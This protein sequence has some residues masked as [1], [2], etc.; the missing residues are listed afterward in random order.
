V[1][2]SGS[3]PPTAAN[4]L[5][6]VTIGQGTCQTQVGAAPPTSDLAESSSAWTFEFLTNG[7]TGANGH[8]VDVSDPNFVLTGSLSML[9]QS[10]DAT[11][12]RASRNIPGA[13]W[14]LSSTGTLSLSL[15]IDFPGSAWRPGSPSITLTSASGGTLT[16][17]PLSNVAFG[18]DQGWVTLAIPLAGNGT[19]QT[20]TSGAFD[21]RNV[22]QIQLSFDSILAGWDLLLDSVFLR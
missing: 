19:W 20:S 18:A 3:A 15:Q 8:V 1:D 21:L 5:S 22:T 13:G 4:V 14:N 12:I 16:L 17:K 2:T 7:V 11:Q 10:L 9:L 6:T